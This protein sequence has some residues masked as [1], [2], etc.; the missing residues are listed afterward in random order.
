MI[1][2]ICISII[3]IVLMGISI[4]YST[5]DLTDMGVDLSGQGRG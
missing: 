1:A 5:K 3:S 2:I 4:R